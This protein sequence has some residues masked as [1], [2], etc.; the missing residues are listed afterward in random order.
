MITVRKT[1]FA[2]NL[3]NGRRECWEAESTDGRWTF[4]RE[5]SP[6]TPWIVRHVDFPGWIGLFG[7]L[8]KAAKWAE[9]QLDLDLRVNLP[10]QSPEVEAR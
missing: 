9:V 6:G 2:Q 3:R 1:E 4:S 10:A 7:S 5:E 8:P